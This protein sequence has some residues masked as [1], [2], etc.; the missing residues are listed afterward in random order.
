[1]INLQQL[2]KTVVKQN[3]TDLHLLAG[4]PPALRIDGRIVRVKSKELSPDDTRKLC[5][6]V[7]TDEQK[8]RFE[9]SKELD[10]SFGIKGMA[11]FRVNL[12]FQRGAVSGV[13]RRV[14]F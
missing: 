8:A 4:A 6:S 2:L 5:Y 1:M 9:Q 3:A 7:L 12:L 13:F 14:P 11:R 10:F